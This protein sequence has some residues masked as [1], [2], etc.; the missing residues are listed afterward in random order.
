MS[1]TD[2][3]VLMMPVYCGVMTMMAYVMKSGEVRF[4]SGMAGEKNQKKVIEKYIE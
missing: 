3:L 4:Q 2:V 1:I